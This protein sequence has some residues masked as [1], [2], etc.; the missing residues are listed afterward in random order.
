MESPSAPARRYFHDFAGVAKRRAYH[1]ALMYKPQPVSPE[2]EHPSADTFSVY[3]LC[4]EWCGTCREYRPGFQALDAQFPGVRFH[5]LDIEE[6]ADDLGDLDIENFPTLLIMRGELVL[7]F[8]T[9]LPHLGHLQRT[10]EVF[11][12]QN[13]EESRAYARSDSERKGWQENADLRFLGNLKR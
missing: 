1:R 3:C 8:G 11:L 13:R 6:R 9:M 10:L 5:W 4:A 2:T 12:A 7:F